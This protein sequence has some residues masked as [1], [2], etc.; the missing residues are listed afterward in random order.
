MKKFLKTFLMVML[1]IPAMAVL[2]DC[3][4]EPPTTPEDESI[5][6]TSDMIT[7]SQSNYVYNGYEHTPGVS[8]TINGQVYDI[9]NYATFENN[10]NA[11]HIIATLH[12]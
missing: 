7:L 5:S 11:Y 12:Y 1:L 10:I 8:I 9:S 2:A 4:E 6:I 3:T